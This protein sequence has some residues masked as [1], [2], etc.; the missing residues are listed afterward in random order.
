MEIFD[1]IDESGRPTGKTVDRETAHAEGI[2]HRTAHVWLLRRRGD[3]TEVLLQKRSRNK[4]SH[5]GCYDISS[6]GHIPAGVDFVPSALRE[7]KEE[8]GVDASAEELVC[9]GRRR[10]FHRDVFYGRDFVD[11][12]VSNI[13]CMWKDI[14]PEQMTLQKEEVEEVIWMD[15]ELCR[16]LVRTNGIPH[17]I[18]MEELDMLPG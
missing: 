3:R 15:L 9:C 8:L 7:L 1:I 13:Y 11:N 4:D 18:Y 16:E 2:L 17:C 14:E 6:A 12:Q 10:I 5:P